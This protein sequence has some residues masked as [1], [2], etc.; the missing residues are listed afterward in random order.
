[1]DEVPWQ[2]TLTDNGAIEHPAESYTVDRSGMHPRPDDSARVLIR[3]DEDPASPQ[4]CRLAAKQVDTPETVSELTDESQPE[5]AAGMWYGPVMGGQ[6]APNPVFINEDANSQG[7][8]L[9]DSRAAPGW[10]ALFCGANGIDEVFGGSYWPG[11]TP[12]LGRKQ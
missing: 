12:A 8:L 1:M 4:G 3:D 9:S 11:L 6:D 7:D 10:I 5:G 2:R